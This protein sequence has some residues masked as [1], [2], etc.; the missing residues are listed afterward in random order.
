MRRRQFLSGVG[1]TALAWPLAARAQRAI[2]FVGFLNSGSPNERAH[3]VE[4]F[5]Q[6]LKDGGYLDGKDVAIEYR[7][8]E[9]RLCRLRA[10]A[11]GRVRRNV[12]V[13][14]AAGGIGPGLGAQE[15]RAA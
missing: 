9:G 4:A 5:R 6:G 15:S 12:A 14:L 10:L 7:W 2:P 3:L 13:M 11:T 1:A 8:A